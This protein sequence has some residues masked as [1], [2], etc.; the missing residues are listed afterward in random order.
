[1]DGPLSAYLCW[2]FEWCLDGLMDVRGHATMHK[3]SQK[4]HYFALFFFHKK[5]KEAKSTQM[6]ALIQKFSSLFS[7]LRQKI[8]DDWLVE[9]V[10]F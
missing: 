10:L 8:N 6:D 2:L 4:M 5:I 7:E 3:K 1:M 9:K